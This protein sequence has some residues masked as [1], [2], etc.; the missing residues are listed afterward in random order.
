MNHQTLRHFFLVAPMI[1]AAIG[2][3]AV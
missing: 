2:R 3:L 1:Y